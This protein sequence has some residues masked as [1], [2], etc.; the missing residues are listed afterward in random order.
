MMLGS[1]QAGSKMRQMFLGWERGLLIII[2]KQ[3]VYDQFVE[4]FS[5]IA[6]D[7]VNPDS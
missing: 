4:Y 2:H 5:N 6:Y 3:M 7:I 1:K